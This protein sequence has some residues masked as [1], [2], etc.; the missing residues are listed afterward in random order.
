MR[1]PARSRPV[2]ALVVAMVAVAACGGEEPESAAPGA[3]GSAASPTIDAV[4]AAER[5]FSATSVAEGTRAAFLAWFADD[6]VAFSPAPVR[7]T[8]HIEAW[9][10]EGPTLEWAPE[11][12]EISADGRMGYTLGPYRQSLPDGGVAW[13]HYHSMWRL[14][15][16]GRW[17]VALDLGTP[18]GP[19]D[20]P[21]PAVE[22]AG[23]G[24]AS[25]AATP[26]PIAAAALL[27]RDRAYGVAYASEGR[28]PAARGFAAERVRVSRTGSPPHS[29]RAAALADQAAA[30]ERLE[31]TPEGA[32]VAASGDLG[33][34]WGSGL[35]ERA[36][37]GG[38]LRP[39]SYARFWRWDAEAGWQVVV[40]VVAAHPPAPPGG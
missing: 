35:V 18:H 3:E 7:G 10:T 33:Y 24:S 20:W 15:D 9:P 1:L 13:G 25:L 32:E 31:W 4:V 19:V 21:P 29:G 38:S 14:D 27:D 36:D 12:A 39:M 2:A 28:E 37:L 34:T 26:A 40:E 30:G 8:A 5:A 16:D 11:R 22:A 6:A 17:R 23:P